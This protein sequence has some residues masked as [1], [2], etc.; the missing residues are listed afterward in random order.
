MYE[1]VLNRY[2]RT[3]YGGMTKSV[4][5]MRHM[6]QQTYKSGELI[7]ITQKNIP[8]DRFLLWIV[9]C[10]SPDE[11]TRSKLAHLLESDR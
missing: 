1:Q 5:I 7:Q 8:A 2:K 10:S 6:G 3:L 9:N 11:V 4:T